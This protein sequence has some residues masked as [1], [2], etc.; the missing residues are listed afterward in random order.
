M[1]AN[2]AQII[3]RQLDVRFG[4][5]TEV[6]NRPNMDGRNTVLATDIDDFRLVLS[7]NRRRITGYLRLAVM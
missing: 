3:A 7:L 5:L 4:S 6:H 1:L 2:A